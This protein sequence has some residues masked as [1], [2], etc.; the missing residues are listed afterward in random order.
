[1]TTRPTATGPWAAAP[2][3]LTL[4]L[5]AGCT[6]SPFRPDA[7]RD[8]RR[9]VVET[10]RRELADAQRRP[11]PVLTQTEDGV[12]RLGIEPGILAELETM[13]G[14]GANAR[15]P[16][17]LG[18]DLMGQP[19]RSM[20]VSLK[21]AMR[22]A[23]ER[24]L[25]VQFA[26]LSPAIAET[27][28]VAAEAAFDATLFATANWN[29]TDTPR[30][31][32]GFGGSATSNRADQ[33]Q[34]L[35]GQLGIRRTLIS[36]GRLT[37]QHDY[38]YTDNSTPGLTSDPNPAHQV[39]LTLQW[40]QPLL[41]GAGSDA[42]LAEVRLARNAERNQV[43]AL[44]RQLLKTL[45]DTERT[46]WQLVQ[47][48]RDVL[49]LRRLLE[50]GELVRGQLEQRRPIDANEAQISDAV[51]RIESRKADLQRAQT[52]LKLVSDRLR[53]LIN[54]PT[55][56]VG[57]DIV[58]IPADDAVEAPIRFSL[59][60]CLSTAIRQRPEVQ[61][62]ILSIDDTSIRR[63]AADNARLPDLNVRLQAR[64]GE[65]G[66]NAAGAYSTLPDTD[67]VDFVVGLAFEMPI[68]NRKA[69]ADYHRRV[70]ERMQAA[71]SYRNT[72]QQI[73][74]EVKDALHRVILNYRQINQSRTSR[75]AAANSLFVLLVEKERSQGY[76]IERLNV[77][78]SQQER[79][80]QVEREEMQAMT[81]Y[82]AALSDL[83]VAMGTA[84]ERN[85]IEFIVPNRDDVSFERTR[86]DFR[87]LDRE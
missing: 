26:R 55:L 8:L 14:P 37:V 34:A 74:G 76:T 6:Q 54:D 49:I 62:A 75:V 30:V 41:K 11:E 78:F 66:D 82:N 9:S 85:G 86:I 29:N 57:S 71:I 32:T 31:S 15:T 47:A 3:A 65:L 79:L 77:E 69:E 22:S 35:A 7:E 81:E 10:A 24:N 28:V 36:G 51:A 53:T 72:V 45:G 12:A 40:D 67:F 1:M 52:Q 2:V 39:A 56:P 13:A 5:F 48:H 63:L 83:F 80:A 23:A 17:L 4:A 50:R 64:F 58:L 43:Q 16:L 73:T 84:L 18:P 68:G 70:L 25:E 46:Y 44:K 33:L 42:T 59:L 87:G 19:Q 27:Q 21:H 60:E 61:Q 38:S 20:P